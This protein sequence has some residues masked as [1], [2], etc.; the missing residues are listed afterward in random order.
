MAIRSVNPLNKEKLES[1]STKRLLAY[2]GKLNQC[3]ESI[4]LSDWSENEVSSTG[5][6]VLKS[7]EEWKYQ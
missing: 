1:L 7:S 4:E 2:L 3:E 6:I 5:G